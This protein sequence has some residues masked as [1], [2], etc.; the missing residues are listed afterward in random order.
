MLVTAL[1]WASDRLSCDFK[2]GAPIG[3]GGFGQVHSGTRIKD[4]LSV[5]IKSIDKHKVMGWSQVRL[6]SALIASTITII[7]INYNFNYN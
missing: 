3:R 7:I 5:A 4:N 2:I 1:A 6:S